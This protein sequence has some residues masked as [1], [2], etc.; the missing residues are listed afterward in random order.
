MKDLL[1]NNFCRV[2]AIPRQS[3]NEEKIANFFV[4]VAKRNNLYYYK[5]QNNNVL[6]KKKG[7]INCEPIALQAHLDMVCIKEISSKHNFQKD[8]IEVIIKGDE[9]T[10]RDTS[11]GADQGVGLSMILSILEDNSLKHPNLEIILTSEEETT[12]NGAV[13]F[14]YSKVESRRMINL[15]NSKDDTIFV[16]ADG[17]FCNEYTFKGNLIKVNYPSYKIVISGF[18]G[19]N[20]GDNADISQNN[21]ITTIAQLLKNK[22]ILLKSINGGLSENDIATTCEVV[23]NTNLDV[24]KIFEPYEVKIEKIGNDLCFS[25][26]DTKQ[27]INQILA[28][29]SGY[30]IQN[31]VSAN[32]GL[33]KTNNDEV[34]IYYVIRSS[35]EKELDEINTKC[36]S[37]NNKFQC[38]E[39]YSD[40]IWKEDKSSKLLEIYREV[41]FSEYKSYPKEEICR[42]SIECSAIKKRIDSLD[43][44]SIGSNMENIHTAKE[45]T[46]ISSWIKIYKLLLQTLES[47]DVKR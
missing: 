9:V 8:G 31:S 27:I 24:Y 29:K 20:S 33:I 37:L 7:C 18:Q 4:D 6:I 15:D 36:K 47:F 34:K 12:F 11:L 28:L 41:Y 14:P 3:G 5:D 19:G 1:I 23:L 43:I 25:K 46:Y 26:E 39:I 40:S 30:I 16:G 21:A 17:D 22:D 38:Q 32:L 45:K 35:N 42:G 2:S 10:A 13:T 44:I